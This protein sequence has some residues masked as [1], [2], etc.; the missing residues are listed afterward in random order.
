MI[1]GDMPIHVVTFNSF[2]F[3][4]A[5]IPQPVPQEDAWPMRMGIHVCVTPIV[6]PE[7]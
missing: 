3:V 7:P 4:W 2:V 5:V 6:F 1:L